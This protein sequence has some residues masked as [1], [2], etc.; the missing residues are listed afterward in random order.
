[1]RSHILRLR[2]GVLVVGVERA[3]GTAAHRAAGE[4]GGPSREGGTFLP[5]RERRAA[6]LVRPRCRQWRG[7][8]PIVGTRYVETESAARVR[9]ATTSISAH[10]G[11]RRP[12]SS[13]NLL[14]TSYAGTLFCAA[15]TRWLSPRRTSAPLPRSRRCIARPA[16]AAPPPSFA[17]GAPRPRARRRNL[18]P[19]SPRGAR[20][21]VAPPRTSRAS[22]AFLSRSARPR[23]DAPR[24]YVSARLRLEPAAPRRPRRAA[25]PRG[26]SLS[27]ADHPR[28]AVRFFFRVVA[29]AFA[30]ERR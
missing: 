15:Q 26:P 11:S 8:R 20:W 10:F 12:V 3:P 28:C 27:V 2:L 25:S 14:D 13:E 1:M 6:G 22:P 21:R 29:N 7:S 16:R 24:W 4:S 19:S 18:P 23:A 9:Q 30:N 5:C 17:A